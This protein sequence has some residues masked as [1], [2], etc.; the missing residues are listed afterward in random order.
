MKKISVSDH[1]V[2]GMTLDIL[3]QMHRDQW[4]PDYVVGIT[5]GGLPAAN[6]ISQYLDCPMQTL[7]VSLRHG[8][9]DS[10]SNLWMAED[11]FGSVPVDKQDVIMS[12]WD[13]S[14]RKKILIVDDINDT[15]ATID[16]IMQDWQSGCFPHQTE[17]WHTVW[18]NNV[19]FAVLVDN[20]SSDC[21]TKVDY[22]AR[23]INKAEDDSWIVFPWENWWQL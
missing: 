17:T 9:A 21:R 14:L 22:Y 10:E 4:Q 16:W 6:L 23:E 12:R 19:R 2:R 11:A 15:G 20:L 8:K 1:E 18:H 3:R 5:R 13:P 7:K